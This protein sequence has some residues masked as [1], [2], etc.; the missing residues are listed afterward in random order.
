AAISTPSLT[1]IHQP[2]GE[3][4]RAAVAA[5]L[6]RLRNPTLPPRQILL[7]A[8]LVERASTRRR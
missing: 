6:Q 5:M 1:T 2:C 7:D 3:I 4:A 8:K